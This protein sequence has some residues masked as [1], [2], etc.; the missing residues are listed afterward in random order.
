MT[1]VAP[2]DGGRGR[3]TA[4]AISSGRAAARSKC[5]KIVLLL[6]SPSDKN[7][8]F[9]TFFLLLCIF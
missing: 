6:R 9:V 4:T 2:G 3:R 7:T 1:I 8:V 5:Y